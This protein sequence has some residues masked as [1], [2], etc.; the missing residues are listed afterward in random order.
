VILDLAAGTG[1]LTRLLLPYV[2]SV[3]AVEPVASMRR[4]LAAQLPMVTPIEGAAEAIPIT[5]G[6]V[7]AVFVGEAFHW[8]D[9]TEAAA[10]IAR[11]LVQGG[12]LGLLWNT[13]TW[14]DRE[15]PWLPAFRA[16]VDDHKRAAGTYPAGDGEWEQ[17][18]AADTD[19]TSLTQAPSALQQ[20]VPALHEPSDAGRVLGWLARASSPQRRRLLPMPDKLAI[21]DGDVMDVAQATIPVTDEGLLRGDGVFEVVRL[22]GGR[23]YGLEE[24]LERMARSAATLRLPFDIDAIRDDVEK[25]LEHS[26][27]ADG[28][29]RLLATRGG[30]RIGIIEDLP[31]IPDTV[32]LATVTY[33]PTRVLD[34]VKSLSYA[35]NMLASRIARE[36]GADEA[37]LVTPHGRVLEGP[38]TSFFYVLD[39]ALCTPP[40][41]DRILDSITRRALFAVTDATERITTLD[42]LRTA[43]EAFLASSAREVQPVR[44]IDAIAIPAAPGPVSRAAADA[45]SAYIEARL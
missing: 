25:L 27:P 13:P 28:G 36:R 17:A 37:L 15:A 23:P 42:D 30:R 43:T 18:L 21:L 6:S 20:P 1:K 5:D 35:A 41:E 22:Y 16:I 9:T 3:I 33:A 45:V 39:G 10:E 4:E 24:H 31:V 14:T 12:G 38:T 8:F 32:G 11:V 19:T 2:N 44:A 7:G 34:G 26:E 40:L 29:L